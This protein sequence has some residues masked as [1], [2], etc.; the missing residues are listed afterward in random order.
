M[1]VELS[2]KQLEKRLSAA[3][4][5]KLKKEGFESA[6]SAGKHC[7]YE[8]IERELKEEK[9][10]ELRVIHEAVFDPKYINKPTYRVYIRK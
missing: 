10:I 8:M 2:I 3:W 1:E 9:P 5:K 6:G 4:E 7:L